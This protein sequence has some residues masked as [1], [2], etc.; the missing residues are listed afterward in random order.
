LHYLA[1]SYNSISNREQADLFC[2]HYFDTVGWV[3][4]RA[5]DL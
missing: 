4:Q 1:G 5:S 2:F 3:S